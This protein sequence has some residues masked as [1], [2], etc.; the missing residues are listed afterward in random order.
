M[1]KF[2]KLFGIFTALLIVAA[3]VNFI[4]CSD[5]DDDEDTPGS[6]TKQS[7]DSGSGVITVTSGSEVTVNAGE[8]ITVYAAGKTKAESGETDGYPTGLTVTAAGD[9]NFKITADSTMNDTST[10][11]NL[12]DGSE[13]DEGIN[14]TV[15]VYNPYFIVNF[16]LDDSLASEVV[17]LSVYYDNN[18]SDDNKVSDTIEA[19]LSS[20]KKTATA[21][22][23][24]S[25]A[26]SNYSYF[27]NIKVTGKDSSG[28][29]V[30]ITASPTYFKYD[31]TSS[32][33][34]ADTITLTKYSASTQNM[35]INFSG[36][37]TNPVAGTITYGSTDNSDEISES[38]TT[39]VDMVIAE[40][41]AS[42]T[43][44]ISTDY[45]NS[46]S[47]FYIS[48]IKLYSDADK[49]KEI[50]GYSTTYSS[51][52]AWQN[53]SSIA[54]VTLVFIPENA[55]T[56][57]TKKVTVESEGYTQ[58]LDAN[59][60]IDSTSNSVF[61][62]G[63]LFVT[64]SSTDGSW[65]SISG[66]N[67][68]ATKTYKSEAIN[69]VSIISTSTFINAI[70]E[71]GLY[72]HS[73]TGTFNVTVQYILGTPTD[74]SD[75]TY[76]YTQIGETKSFTSVTGYKQVLEA[77]SF[78]SLSISSLKVVV[79]I[80]SATDTS[81]GYW[82]SAS[83]ASSWATGTY[84]SLTWNSTDNG[85]SAE[86]TSETFISALSTNGLYV[87]FDDQSVSG[88]VAVYYATT[89]TSD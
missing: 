16:T 88:T 72:I 87:E 21:S 80:S 83:S 28:S 89:T 49:T 41:N 40:D 8:S 53:F 54:T 20:D 22:F 55:V 69:T 75:P 24:K 12:N 10:T 63:Q 59:N 71:N 66:A 50:T 17:S 29:D 37:D 31:D 78:T 46:S 39:T 35:T 77:S 74:D 30:A 32:N 23:K 13:S 15:K 27:S 38:N 73:S 85:Y 11:V 47:Y 34:Y 76:S 43:V 19:V 65:C 62:I 51:N 7:S 36:F 3:G 86:I 18:Q 5:S 79:T 33:D 26:D 2:K 58:V 52:S 82:A 56:L 1:K 68:W 44:T 48:K 42:A 61:G 45:C 4:S 57:I 67:E 81:G 9:G 64:I 25:I 6:D 70:T 14:L 84:Q 60:F